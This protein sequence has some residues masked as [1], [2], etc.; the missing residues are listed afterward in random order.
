MVARISRTLL[1]EILEHADRNAADEVC[2]LLLGEEGRIV[3][4]QRVANVASNPADRFEIDPAALFAQARAERAGGARMIGHYHS[5]PNG[6]A[7]PSAMD[8]AAVT[9]P[10]MLWLIVAN[11]AATLWRADDPHGL[12]GCFAA[13]ELA[14]D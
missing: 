5:H 2:G 6:R 8:A 1:N 7:T 12:H 10:A 3:S 14:I 9:D 11:G 4:A 13:M